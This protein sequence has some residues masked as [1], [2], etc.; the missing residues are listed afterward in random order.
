MTERHHP[1]LGDTLE[2]FGRF[3]CWAIARLLGRECAGGKTRASLQ[4]VMLLTDRPRVLSPPVT[5]SLPPGTALAGGA[6]RRW[7]VLLQ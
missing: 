5:D 6:R 4:T 3:V 1:W 7:P 2:T